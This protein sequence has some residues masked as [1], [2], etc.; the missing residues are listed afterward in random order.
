MIDLTNYSLDEFEMFLLDH[1]RLCM[2]VD[3]L[4]EVHLRYKGKYFS[5]EPV[6]GKVVV[7]AFGQRQEFDNVDDMLENCV[8]D[9]KPFMEAL[10]DVESEDFE[11]VE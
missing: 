1:I 7:F 9:G 4:N 8:I 10:K 2:S 6:K 5:I 3:Y 11:L